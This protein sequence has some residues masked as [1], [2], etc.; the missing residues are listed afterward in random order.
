MQ[1]VAKSELPFVQHEVARFAYRKDLCARRTSLKSLQDKRARMHLQE[2]C[3]ALPIFSERSSEQYLRM[4]E[5]LECITVL[6][7]II[8]VRVACA[9]FCDPF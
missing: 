1:A 7:I 2:F 4:M 6:L 9:I 5:A 3:L 8:T